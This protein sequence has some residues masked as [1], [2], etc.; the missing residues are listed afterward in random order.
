[1][2][3]LKQEVVDIVTKLLKDVDVKRI[4]EIGTGWGESAAFFSELKPHATIYTIDAYGLYGD[5]RIYKDFTHEKVKEVVQNLSRNCIQILGNSQTIH[6]ELPI[7]VLFIDGDHT[8]DGCYRDFS[9]FFPFVKPGGIIIF[10]DYNQP[11]NKDNGVRAAV[12]HALMDYNV[13]PVFLGYYCAILKL[14]E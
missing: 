12:S 11:N 3:M 1:M 14:H 4:V 9:N 5:G 10:D 2:H 6:W 7:D 8:F 13:S